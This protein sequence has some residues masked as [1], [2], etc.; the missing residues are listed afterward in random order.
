MTGKSQNCLRSCA[1]IQRYRTVEQIS[2]GTGQAGRY[3]EV[4]D[5][6]A[7]IE[8]VQE[9]QADTKRYWTVRDISRGT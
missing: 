1:D 2:R 3:H 5:R 7:D 4:Q 8:K 9:S 6:Q